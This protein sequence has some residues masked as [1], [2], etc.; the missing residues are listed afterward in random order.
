[1][2]LILFDFL[3]IKN[4]TFLIHFYVHKITYHAFSSL[5]ITDC[6]VCKRTL[7]SVCHTTFHFKFSV[8]FQQWREASNKRRHEY[9]KTFLQ[10]ASTLLNEGGGYILVHVD[11]LSVAFFDEQVR[12]IGGRGGRVEGGG[13]WG[14][15]VKKKKREVCFKFFS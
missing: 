12:I 6:A 9:L 4:V 2:V 13:D 10:M 14:G 1:M 8:D 5:R 15:G 7:W 3:I 11:L